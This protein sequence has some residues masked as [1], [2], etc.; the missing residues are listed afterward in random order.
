[1]ISS[2]HDAL[3]G[4]TVMVSEHNLNINVSL[5][6]FLL[7]ACL[8]I[9]S[10]F[11]HNVWSRCSRLLHRYP[12]ILR[13][14]SYPSMLYSLD[15]LAQDS[16]RVF[17]PTFH[18]EYRLHFSWLNDVRLELS[19]LVQPFEAGSKQSRVWYFYGTITKERSKCTLLRRRKIQGMQ[20]A[21]SSNYGM[22]CWGQ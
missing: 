19:N 14:G 8:L 3:F 7:R 4:L 22:E 10:T 11:L 5:V 18:G 17:E 12:Y 21:I 6:R 15:A 13:C 16:S 1:M 9:V 2:D 20:Y